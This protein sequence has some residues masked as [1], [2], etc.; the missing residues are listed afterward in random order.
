MAKKLEIIICT[1]T[2]C[3]VQG[4]ASLLSIED[5]LDETMKNQVEIKGSPCL[6]YCKDALSTKSPYVIIG[7]DVISGADIPAVLEK[8]KTKLKEK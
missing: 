2:N 1:G 6:G 7:T 8:I 4:G 5:Y 3:Y